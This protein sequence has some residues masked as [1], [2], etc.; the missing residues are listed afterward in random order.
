MTLHVV[1]HEVAKLPEDGEGWCLREGDWQ[2]LNVELQNICDI[3][4]PLIR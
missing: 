4:Q 3:H 2:L 1:A